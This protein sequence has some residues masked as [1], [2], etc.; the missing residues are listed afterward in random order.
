MH[1]GGAVAVGTA[2]SACNNSLQSAL[3]GVWVFATLK[4]IFATVQMFIVQFFV[5]SKALE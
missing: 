3:V 5:G 2:E 4:M 1:A